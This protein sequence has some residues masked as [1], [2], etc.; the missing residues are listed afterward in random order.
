[1]ESN[2]NDLQSLH[3]F[4]NLHKAIIALLPFKQKCSI[5]YFTSKIHSMISFTEMI[6]LKRKKTTMI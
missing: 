4:S 6:H 1:M 5:G 3:L 2:F